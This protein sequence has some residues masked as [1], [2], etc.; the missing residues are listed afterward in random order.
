VIFDQPLNSIEFNS[1]KPAAL[2]QP[3][4]IDPELGVAPVALDMNKRRRVTVAA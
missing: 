1:T 2:L 4:R 3:H